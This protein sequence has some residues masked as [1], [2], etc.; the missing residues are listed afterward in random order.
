MVSSYGGV[1]GRV[2]RL[3]RRRAAIVG[4]YPET[5][6][7]VFQLFPGQW[8]MPIPDA[9]EPAKSH[10]R[11]LSADLIDQHIFDAAKVVTCGIIARSLYVVGANKPPGGIPGIIQRGHMRP[12]ALFTCRRTLGSGRSSFG[13]LDQPKSAAST[14]GGGGGGGSGGMG[15]GGGGTLI[16]GVSGAGGSGGFRGAGWMRLHASHIETAIALTSHI[17]RAH[18]RVIARTIGKID[19]IGQSSRSPRWN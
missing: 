8:I 7:T 17:G 9:K 10:D 6:E 4:G 16:G 12:F 19:A 5:R 3:S 2:G 15:I 11:D 1:T 13:P 18:L 14:R